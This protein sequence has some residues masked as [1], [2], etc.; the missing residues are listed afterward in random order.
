MKKLAGVEAP[1]ANFFA[2]GVLAL[3]AKLG[4]VLWQ[5]PPNLGYDPER[6]AAFFAQLPRT[7][8]AG[9]RA[10]RPARRADGGPGAAD[11]RR[12]TGRCGTRSRCGTTRSRRPASSSCCASTTSRS[13][14]P[15]PP[16]SGRRCSTSPPTSSTCGCTATR[17]STS[18]GTIRRRW[19]AGRPG[20]A[21]GPPAARPPTGPCSPRRPRAAQGRGRLLRQRRQGAGAVRRDRAGR[22]ARRL[23]AG[24]TRTCRS[25]ATAT[26]DEQARTDW[27]E[28]ARTG[29]GPR[30]AARARRQSTDDPAR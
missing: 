25:A 27:P 18:A 22:P 16:G 20:S 4:P 1:L 21:P 24:P 30:A 15:T 10:G 12:P 14:S 23:T 9:R 26:V 2:S 7:T 5:L 13:S 28:I 11:H 19:T 29:R 17:S 3:G 6:L 8:G